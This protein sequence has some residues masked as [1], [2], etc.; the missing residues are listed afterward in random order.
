MTGLP[1]IDALSGVPRLDLDTDN[2]GLRLRYRIW[3]DQ[4][5]PPV[6]LQHGAKD[7]GRSWDYLVG[8]LVERFCCIVPDL[9]GHGDS[10][11]APGGGYDTLGFVTDFATIIEA[12]KG[13]GISGPYGIIGHSLGGAITMRYAAAFPEDVQFIAN[14]EGL[15]FSQARYQRWLAEPI[16]EKWRSAVRRRRAVATRTR[17]QHRDF[18]LAVVQLAKVHAHLPP[19][20]V[21]YLA[22]H[23]VRWDEGGVSWKHDPAIQYITL[24]AEPPSVIEGM[25]S[26]MTLPVGLF[27]GGQSFL[28]PFDLADSRFSAFPNATFH[29]YEDSGHWLHHDA[30]DRFLSDFEAFL[31]AS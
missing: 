28:G 23:G 4:A 14:I 24:Q 20:E 2:M 8:S 26:E 1:L 22:A 11:W 18:D 15:G 5:N 3:G 17:R 25:H 6:I 30:R 10:A 19:D 21:E 16:A 29:L 31:R 7:H 9:R 13:Q 27:Y 12:L